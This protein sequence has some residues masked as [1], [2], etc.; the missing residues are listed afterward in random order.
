MNFF[1]GKLF[2]FHSCFFSL[3]CPEFDIPISLNRRCVKAAKITCSE[4]TASV[5]V[6]SLPA[7]LVSSQSKNIM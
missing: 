4:G 1:V 3:E 5:Y 6:I 2:D 7:G